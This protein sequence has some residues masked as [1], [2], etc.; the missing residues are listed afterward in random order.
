M[1]VVARKGIVFGYFEFDMNM[2][3]KIIVDG[4]QRAS[5]FDGEPED[6]TLS[7]NFNDVYSIPDLMKMAWE[8]G[9]NNEEF[10]VEVEEVETHSRM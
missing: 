1:K 4:E 7:R 5:F 10:V 2:N 6:N 8:A 3:F 9:K